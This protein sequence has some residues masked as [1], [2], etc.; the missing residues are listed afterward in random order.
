LTAY[1]NFPL[2]WRVGGDARNYSISF[3]LFEKRKAKTFHTGFLQ[4]SSIFVKKSEESYI[5]VTLAKRPKSKGQ[6]NFSE[7]AGQ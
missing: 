5:G 3:F 7:K 1:R 4:S 6:S 2:S